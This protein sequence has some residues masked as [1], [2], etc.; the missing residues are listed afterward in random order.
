MI[1]LPSV[2]CE[3]IDF[4]YCRTKYEIGQPLSGQM[5]NLNIT[6]VELGKINEE[7]GGTPGGLPWVLA[8]SGSL[9]GEVPIL[10]VAVRYRWYVVPQDRP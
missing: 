8:C 7:E 2:H 5:C 10:L 1:N 3:S 9:G 4:L 6:D